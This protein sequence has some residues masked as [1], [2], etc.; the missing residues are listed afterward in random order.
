MF[1]DGYGF[2]M[3][4]SKQ[5]KFKEYFIV[6]SQFLSAII[7][8]VYII[9]KFIESYDPRF[10]EPATKE[11]VPVKLSILPPEGTYEVGET[12]PMQ[13]LVN[14]A[15]QPINAVGAYLEFPS[16][17]V[18]V[19]K[20]DTSGSFCTLFP[21]NSFDNST[22]TITYSC[23]LP[24]PG[25]SENFGIVGT[26]YIKFKKPGYADIFFSEK[27]KVLANDKFGT[28]ILTGTVGAGYNII[29]PP[30]LSK[31]PA[32]SEVE[33]TPSTEQKTSDIG[34]VKVES[35][36]H[37][38]PLKWY[39]NNEVE[40]SWASVETAV[41]YSFVLDKEP[42]TKPDPNVVF[43]LNEVKYDYVEDGIW[44]F[45]IQAKNESK[46]SPISHYKIQIDTSEPSDLHVL[47]AAILES[48]DAWDVNIS[49]NDSLSGIA[50]YEIQLDSGK[51]IQIDSD[52]VI[53][54]QDFPSKKLQII[55]YDFAGN[56]ISLEYQLP[57]KE[58][59]NLWERIVSFF[60][61][62]LNFLREL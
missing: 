26:F 51:V 23:G 10:A 28:N 37:P 58:P 43:T 45:H 62:V 32:V 53:S 59:K 38:D 2:F 15:E 47:S 21:E 19:V 40:L 50:K 7:L 60:E 9:P 44:Y 52:T 34:P 42:F 49:C 29:E 17:L 16:D 48:E 39:S 1:N 55:A 6:F 30:Y 11:L 33:F 35:L 18:E 4:K 27:S 56:S 20:I 46:E 22:G 24:T 57:S 36:T 54:F 31:T 14:I 12:L 5:R 13:V 8:G 61:S 41:Y 25:F 3:V